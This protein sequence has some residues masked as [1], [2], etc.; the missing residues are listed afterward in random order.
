MQPIR[1]RLPRIVS[2]IS[3]HRMAADGWCIRGKT[4]CCG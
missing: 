4:T 1:G 2:G 3:A